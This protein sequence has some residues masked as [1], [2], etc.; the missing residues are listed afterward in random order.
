MYAL[1]VSGAVNTQVLCGWFLCAIYIYIYT[2]F[3]SFIHS[4]TSVTQQCY[5]LSDCGDGRLAGP[6]DLLVRLAF[7]RWG[8]VCSEG[9]VRPGSGQRSP[10]WRG[11]FIDKWARI[12]EPPSSKEVAS[13]Y[14]MNALVLNPCLH[15]VL[16]FSSSFSY[17][18]FYC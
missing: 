16:A 8:S 6:Y 4:F 15:Y 3:H 11:G 13:F 9:Q 7:C 17:I 14:V 1:C 10:G 2:H 12:Y 18:H 5:A